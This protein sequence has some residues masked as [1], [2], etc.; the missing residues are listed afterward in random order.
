VAPNVQPDPL[1]ASRLTVGWLRAQLRAGRLPPPEPPLN[2]FYANSIRLRLALAQSHHPQPL[3]CAPVQPPADLT[4][5]KGDLLWFRDRPM[6]VVSL[7]H[8]RP[9]HA[10]RLL[11]N[12]EVGQGLT[13]QLDDL[14]IRIAA[15][16]PLATLRFGRVADLPLV[17]CLRSGPPLIKS[18]R[19]E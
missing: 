5:H 9:V 1:F 6:A 19:P 3:V 17:V 11:F 16:P 7:S 12:P 18:L 15:A 10:S 2:G 8:G 13:A 4:L 14:H